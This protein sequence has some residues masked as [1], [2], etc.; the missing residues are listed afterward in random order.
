MRRGDMMRRRIA[1][2]V[3]SVIVPVE[4]SS[5][6]VVIRVLDSSSNARLKRPSWKNWTKSSITFAQF[7][8]SPDAE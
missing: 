5:L 4:P 8:L 7:G 2:P 1:R 6:P 3:R